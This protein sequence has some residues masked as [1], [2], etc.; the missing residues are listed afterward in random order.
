MKNGD[1]VCDLNK[2]KNTLDTIGSE[3]ERKRKLIWGWNERDE[4]TKIKRER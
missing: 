3:R 1:V 2:Y 4:K